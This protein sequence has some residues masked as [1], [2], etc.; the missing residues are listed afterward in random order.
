MKIRKKIVLI[1]VLSTLVLIPILS[2][3]SYVLAEGIARWFTSKDTVENKFKTSDIKVKIEEEFTT[4]DNWDGN[5]IKKEVKI[6]NDNANEELVRVSIEPRWI[7]E[8]NEYWLGNINY[9]NINYVNTGQSTNS[10]WVDGEDGYYY[11]N[12][13]LYKN[14]STKNIISSVTLNIPENEKSLY[15][16]KTLLI[17]VNAEAI[18]KSKDAFITVWGK[19]LSQ[20]IVDLL[21]SLCE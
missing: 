9:V 6:T 21:T 12:K 3:K 4:P 17:D 15:K 13:V 14:E 16:G 2:S 20:T 11:Y 5:T 10:P 8:N 19:N 18:Q 1:L 7:D